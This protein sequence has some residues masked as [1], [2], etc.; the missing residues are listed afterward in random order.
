MCS[1]EN[2]RTLQTVRD[3]ATTKR[4]KQCKKCDFVFP[5]L[6]KPCFANYPTKEEIEEYEKYADEETA[7]S[8]E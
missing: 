6:E 2:L 4:V 3:G 8:Q 7:K 1:C 5:T